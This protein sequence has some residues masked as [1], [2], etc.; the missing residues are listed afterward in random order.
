MIRVLIGLVICLMSQNYVRAETFCGVVTRS[1]NKLARNTRLWNIGGKIV[2]EIESGLA[3]SGSS[4]TPIFY[5]Q[6]PSEKLI[7]VLSTSAAGKYLIFTRFSRGLAVYSWDQ[8]RIDA[9]IM[10]LVWSHALEIKLNN[11]TISSPPVDVIAFQSSAYVLTNFNLFIFAIAD[12]AAGTY[13]PTI[14]TMPNCPN[15]DQT[16]WRGVGM[17]I[18]DSMLTIARMSSQGGALVRIDQRRSLGSAVNTWTYKPFD[19][20]QY[21]YVNILRPQY[22]SDLFSGNALVESLSDRNLM[23]SID[24]PDG[25]GFAGLDYALEFAPTSWGTGSLDGAISWRKHGVG[26]YA[27][28]AKICQ[29][30]DDGHSVVS[31]HSLGVTTFMAIDSDGYQLSVSRND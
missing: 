25:V 17:I 28:G 11:R 29:L 26:L 19:I 31:Q 6:D 4:L 5:F 30:F 14:E 20:G 13:K 16:C 15:F 24:A 10:N 1:K 7:A 12:L 21:R 9:P 2:Y 22:S 8:T 3:I 18:R 23:F 27:S